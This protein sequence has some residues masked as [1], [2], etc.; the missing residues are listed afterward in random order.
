MGKDDNAKYF[1][2]IGYIM[3]E[4]E[5]I[6]K[7]NFFT[8]KKRKRQIPRLQLKYKRR[9]FTTLAITISR[10]GLRPRHKRLQA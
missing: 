4:N 1:G 6:Q 8:A 7:R 9:L 5:Q 2:C 10:Q 3:Q